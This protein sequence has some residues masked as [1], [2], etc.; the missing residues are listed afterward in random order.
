MVGLI[1]AALALAATSGVAR[2]DPVETTLCAVVR[3]P[4][5]YDGK[6]ITIRAGVLTDWHHG[7]VLIHSGCKH[8]IE[9]S[10]TEEAELEQAEALDKAVGTPMDGGYDRT[11]MATLTGLFFLRRGKPVGAFDNPLKFVVNRIEAI[12]TYPRR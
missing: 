8:G 3:N 2:P 9:L 6:V 5:A 7:T 12:Q 1:A 11:T 4:K 10:S